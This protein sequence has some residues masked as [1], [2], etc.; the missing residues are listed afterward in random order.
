[1]AKDR[2][3]REE[4]ASKLLETAA[5][6]SDPLREMAEMMAAFIMEAEVS[7]QIGAEPHERSAERSTHRNGYRDRRWDTRLGGVVGC[8]R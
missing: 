8:E 5:R 1:M 7:Q 6:G 2:V 4:L 3:E